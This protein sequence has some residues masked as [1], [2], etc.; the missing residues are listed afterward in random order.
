MDLS[1]GNV[2]SQ[3]PAFKWHEKQRM[4]QRRRELVKAS[5]ALPF[6]L[7]MGTESV[8]V[9]EIET[10]SKYHLCRKFQ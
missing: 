3:K 10:L 5:D 7:C 6:L 4:P 2:A 1:F 8:E 9:S